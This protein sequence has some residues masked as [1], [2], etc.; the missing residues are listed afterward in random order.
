MFKDVSAFLA[1]FAN[2]TPPDQF[3][4]DALLRAVTETV[5]ITL[6][7]N[8]I[9]L[10]GTTAFISAYPPSVKSEILL[11]KSQILAALEGVSGKRQIRDIR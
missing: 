6:S 2:L 10:R 11:H 4:K 7:K 8:A 9:E 3:I 1:R 5:G